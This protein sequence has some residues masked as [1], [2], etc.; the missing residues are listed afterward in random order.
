MCCCSLGNGIEFSCTDEH[1]K[2]L[3]QR[4]NAQQQQQQPQAKVDSNELNEINKMPILSN[5]ASDN[6]TNFVIQMPGSTTTTKQS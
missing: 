1:A 5:S 4:I 2:Y 6:E 3:T